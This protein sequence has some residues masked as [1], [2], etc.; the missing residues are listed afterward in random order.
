MIKPLI[1]LLFLG[2]PS[3]LLASEKNHNSP[4][5]D[6]RAAKSKVEKAICDD[7]VF[8]SYDVLLS[9]TYSQKKSDPTFAKSYQSWTKDRNACNYANDDHNLK[10]C[11]RNQYALVFG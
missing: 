7:A 11:L 9:K 6:C 10:V 3:F 8:S 4:S 5:F 1:A 2:T